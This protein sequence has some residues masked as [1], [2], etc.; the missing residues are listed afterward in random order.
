MK[1]YILKVCIL[2]SIQKN[3][4]KKYYLCKWIWK[5]KKYN[6]LKS[7]NSINKYLT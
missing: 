2:D 1:L 7:T 3:T 5:F 6:I 4:I